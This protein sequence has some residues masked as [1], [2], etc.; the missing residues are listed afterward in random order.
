[1]ARWCRRNPL[2]AGLIAAVILVTA[3]GFLATLWQ[4]RMARVNEQEALKQKGI[5]EEQTE[6]ARHLL[7]ASDLN[8]AQQ[9][10]EAGNVARARELLDRQRPEPGAE[11]LRGFEWRY[12]W[13]L[14]RDQSLHTFRG[15]TKEIAVARF[16]PDGRTLASAS[17]DGT[18]RLWDVATRRGI[19]T[20]VG[21]EAE[22]TSLA[23]TP[24]GK[25][26]I[27]GAWDGGIKLWDATTWR[28]IGPLTGPSTW[29]CVA[30]SPDGRT[31][32]AGGTDPGVHLWD[33]RRRN[34]I[35]VLPGHTAYVNGL[36]FSPEGKILASTC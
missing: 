27:R 21:H 23:F 18:V 4:L 9:A 29:L 34:E 7:Y 1:L 12:L 2:V 32:A 24:D 17:S 33:L 31:L 19:A 36:A 10:W 28:E 16:S 8:V 3:V 14:C 20:L 6:R 35:G 11:D 5:A 15:H 13:R 26:L 25:L 22:V 30:I